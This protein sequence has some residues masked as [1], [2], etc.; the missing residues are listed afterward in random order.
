MKK[1]LFI[2]VG[3]SLLLFIG[4]QENT[5]TDPV[6]NEAAGN[7]K[8]EISSGY[9]LIKLDRLLPDPS[10]P[11]KNYLTLSGTVE[12][13]QR[14][15]Y[16]DP[17]PPIS[18]KLVY[19]QLSMNAEIKDPHSSADVFWTI[20]GKSEDNIR[21]SDDDL[22]VLTKYYK[23][24]GRDDGLGVVCEFEVTTSGVKLGSVK[25]VLSDIARSE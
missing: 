20:S 3:S 12:Y 5:I 8:S 24:Q 19:L 17:V 15:I 21:L 4:C 14:A 9:N 22:V 18:Q 10:V 25:L 7:L 23:V 13:A 16:L 11:F 6:S 1:M 2:L